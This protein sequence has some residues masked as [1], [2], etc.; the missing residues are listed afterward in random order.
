[1]AFIV[2]MVSVAERWPSRRRL[3]FDCHDNV[4]TELIALGREHGWQPQGALE[5]DK[6]G[7]LIPIPTGVPPGYQPIEWAYPMRVLADD[8]ANWADALERALP[9]TASEP[10]APPRPALIREDMTEEEYHAANRG[11]SAELL[12][13]FI[14]FLRHGAFNFAYDD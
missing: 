2:E 12:R 4:W 1:M 3:H 13:E 6:Q 14:T 8:G 7:K 11:L 9:G 5:V 10:V